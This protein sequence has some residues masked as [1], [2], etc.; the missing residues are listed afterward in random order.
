MESKVLALEQE[1]EKLKK[2]QDKPI[3]SDTAIVASPLQPRH[4]P[5][6]PRDPISAPYNGFMVD[7][8]KK[9]YLDNIGLKAEVEIYEFEAREQYKSRKR[10]EAKLAQKEASAFFDSFLQQHK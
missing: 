3:V 5:F 7:A 8:C 4:S 9:I 6:R 2:Q 1:N 10:A